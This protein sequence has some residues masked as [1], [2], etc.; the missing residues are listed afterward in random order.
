MLGV[1]GRAPRPAECSSAT[2]M[3]I[4]Y[5]RSHLISRDDGISACRRKLLEVIVIASRRPRYIQD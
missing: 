4:D 5:R 1:G 2:R 3:V